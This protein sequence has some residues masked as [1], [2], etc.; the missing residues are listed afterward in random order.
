[1]RIFFV[2]FLL[3]S[4]TWATASGNKFTSLISN[5]Q[6]LFFDYRRSPKDKN[7]NCKSNTN[8][9]ISPFI[10]NLAIQEQ[11][12]YKKGNSMGNGKTEHLDPTTG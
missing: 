4:G 10:N 9:Q 12:R 3:F 5:F 7:N 1:M 8:M 6:I 11:R 2:L